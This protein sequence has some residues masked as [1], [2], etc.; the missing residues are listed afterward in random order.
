[1][2]ALFNL[3]STHSSFGHCSSFQLCSCL[4]SARF[5]RFWV[6]PYFMTRHGAPR[7]PRVVIDSGETRACCSSVSVL[8]PRTHILI[9][10]EAQCLN[11]FY[12]FPLSDLTITWVLEAHWVLVITVEL[13]ELLQGQGV[14]RQTGQAVGLPYRTPQGANHTGSWC[15]RGMERR[16][17]GWKRAFPSDNAESLPANVWTW[18]QTKCERNCVVNLSAKLKSIKLLEE[19]TG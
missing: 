18:Y 14:S 16:L 19:N 17:R 8:T 15:L 4:P 2:L 7:P 12:L 1:M 11:C 6:A 10:A 5:H 13:S 3:C 9:E